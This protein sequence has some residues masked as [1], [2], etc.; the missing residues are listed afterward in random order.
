MKHFKLIYRAVFFVGIVSFLCSPAYAAL[1]G[2]CANCHTMHDSQNGI[3]VGADGQFAYLLRDS[4]IG[5]HT[6]T[7]SAGNA[8]PYV[9]SEGEPNYGT[10]TLAGGNF[11]WVASSGGGNDTKGHNVLGISNPDTN[12]TEAPGNP[13]SCASSCHMSL[14]VQQTVVPEYGSGCEGCHL[15]L[16]HHA[17]NAAPGEVTTQ[18]HGWFRF[19]AG[20][21]SGDGLGVEGIEDNDW[22]YTNGAS[23]HNEY[24]GFAGIHTDAA[25][26]YNQGNTMTGYCCGCHG[27]FHVQTDSG[28]WI[29]HPSDA[30]IPDSGEYAAYEVYSTQAPVARPD[31]SGYTGPSSTVTPGTDLVM[32]LSCH[33]AHGSPYPDMLRWDYNTQIAGGG[34]GGLDNTGCFTCHTSKDE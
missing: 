28:A 13:Y 30:V 31:L 19:L 20:H 29:R 26:F 11:Y 25:G 34:G 8:V 24:L 16:K 12:L 3:G 4:C 2:Q 15:E 1:S 22:E 23:D 21:D 9:L 32:C 18:A 14:A 17:P 33:R 5:C 10:D 6:G 7:N 27:E